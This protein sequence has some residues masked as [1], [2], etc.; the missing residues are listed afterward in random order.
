MDLNLS[1]CKIM[2]LGS[3]K[4]HQDHFYSFEIEDNVFFKTWDTRTFKILFTTYVRPILEY[5]SVAWYPHRKHDSKRIERVQRR[6]TKLVPSIGNKNY[7]DRLTTLGLTT[8]EDRRLRGDLIQYFKFDK[9]F[10]CIDWFHPVVQ[11]PS[12]FS[13][14]PAGSTRNNNKLYRQ[15][16]KACSKR[17]HFF[18]NRVIPNWNELPFEVKNQF[19]INGFKNK[20][21]THLSNKNIKSNSTSA[22]A[23]NYRS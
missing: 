8:L 19:T 17:H 12:S 13:T 7:S 3:Q 21:D 5:G 15:L 2:H 6:A 11:C 10:N 4:V 20:L 22:I 9:K 14:G 16:V 23:K 1:K 18:T